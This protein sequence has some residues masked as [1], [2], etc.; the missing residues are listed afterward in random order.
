MSLE[1]RR[2][3]ITA[4]WMGCAFAAAS[5]SVVFDHAGMISF[6]LAVVG[7]TFLA[8]GMIQEFIV[9]KIRTKKERRDE[10]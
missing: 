9:Y 3:V 7:I 10:I 8:I 5:F 2:Q 1:K 4:I 6:V